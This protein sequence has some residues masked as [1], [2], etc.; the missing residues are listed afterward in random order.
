MLKLMPKAVRAPQLKFF[1]IT[2]NYKPT[3]VSV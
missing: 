2:V 3:S 1:I